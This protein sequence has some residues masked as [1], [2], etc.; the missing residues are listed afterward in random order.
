[1]PCVHNQAIIDECNARIDSMKIQQKNLQTNIDKCNDIIN[2]HESFNSELKCVINN[3][4]GNYVQAG[5]AY[6]EGK[7]AMCLNMSE[8]TIANCDEIIEKSRAKYIELDNDINSELNTI[9][10]LQ[11][12]C[13]A[14]VAA[15]RQVN[16][17]KVNI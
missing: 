15:A 8:H 6:D 10:S 3:L 14:C 13:S 16:Y 1:M 17:S 2:K 4:E 12:D 7:M 5:I 9:D 11:G